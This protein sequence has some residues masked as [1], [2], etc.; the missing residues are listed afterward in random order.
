MNKRNGKFDHLIRNL[1]RI[2]LKNSIF[3]YEYRENA[4]SKSRKG[5]LNIW[6]ESFLP[7]T[8]IIL[9]PKI[10]GTI[11]AIQYEDGKLNKA[12]NKFGQDITEIIR[13]Y[14]SIPKKIQLTK[15]I[16][17]QG[18]LYYGLDTSKSKQSIDLLSYKKNSTID[19]EEVKFCAFHIYHC[20]INHYQTLI[21]LKKLNFD[22]P[23]SQYTN[24]ISDIEIYYRCWKEGKLFE[25]YPNSGIVLKIN[26]RKLQKR[27]GENNLF[28]N[29][30]FTIN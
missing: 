10:I 26:S 29:W 9:E 16:E 2:S 15:K 30:A 28:I 23:Q 3:K 24:F 5:S 11:V 19:H 21:E 25:S 18:V 1:E 12:I 13:L 14:K 4:F 17:I 27:L 6:L 20:K 22:I 8:R 7:N